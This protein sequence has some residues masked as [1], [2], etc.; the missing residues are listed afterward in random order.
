MDATCQVVKRFPTA[1][2]IKLMRALTVVL[3]LASAALRGSETELN[4]A[5][6]PEGEPT[7]DIFVVEGSLTIRSR[8]GRK[9]LEISGDH[10]EA[11][12]GAVFGPST[13][14]P[15]VIEAGLAYRAA[16]SLTDLEL[17]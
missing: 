14:G 1:A 9:F 16:Y 5:A 8:E 3:S 13:L 7:R 11:D 10:P 17:D 12:S 15:A 2:A 6:L 4:L